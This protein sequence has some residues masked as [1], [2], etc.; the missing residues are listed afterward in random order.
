MLSGG[1][2]LLNAARRFKG[3][4]HAGSRGR[5]QKVSM[6]FAEACQVIGIESSPTLTMKEVRANYARLANRYHPDKSG[7]AA[8]TEKWH[9]LQQALRI[10]KEGLAQNQGYRMP[11]AN[12]QNTRLQKA[13]AKNAW[14]NATFSMNRVWKWRAAGKQEQRPGLI[15][16]EVQNKLL[17]DVSMQEEDHD[18]ERYST[19]S[20]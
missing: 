3:Y 4:N 2:P 10:L 15:G 6:G 7:S 16:M 11:G 13:K 17:D 14:A 8:T 5:S 19:R 20:R 18:Y 12:T 1:R 9:Q